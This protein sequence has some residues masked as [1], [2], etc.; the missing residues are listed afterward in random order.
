MT[1]GLVF[2][3]ETTFHSVMEILDELRPQMYR[4]NYELKI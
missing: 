2:D 3:H 4:S 1:V